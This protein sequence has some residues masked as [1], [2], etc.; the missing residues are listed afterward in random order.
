ML[1]GR[2]P[3][4]GGAICSQG[5]SS[6]KGKE[7]WLWTTTSALLSHALPF[8]LCLLP[9]CL[10][11]HEKDETRADEEPPFRLL[12]RCGNHQGEVVGS[13]R[14]MLLLRAL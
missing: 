2:V 6:G 9:P 10:S 1:S 8:L 13:R 12:L 5:H 3:E 4:N 14:G 7:G 11:E